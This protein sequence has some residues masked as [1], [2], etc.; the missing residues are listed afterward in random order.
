[1]ILIPNQWKEK[2]ACS[3]EGLNAYVRDSLPNLRA[4]NYEG[5]CHLLPQSTYI[6]EGGRTWCEDVLSVEE[7][8][9]S[10][11]SFMETIGCPI[12]MVDAENE[13]PRC[14]NVTVGD[15]TSETKQLIQRVYKDDFERLGYAM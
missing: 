8:P 14:P 12:R 10:F 9:G 5:A 15:L 1:M 13:S 4:S 7:L 2:Y 6:W 3:Q 11:D